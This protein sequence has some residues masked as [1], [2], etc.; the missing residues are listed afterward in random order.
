MGKIRA[1]TK[2]LMFCNVLLLILTA[3]TCA[4]SVVFNYRHIDDELKPFT[5]VYMGYLKTY[6]QNNNYYNPKFYTI[7]LEPE[8]ENPSW[9][10]VCEGKANGYKIKINKEWWDNNTD[11]DGRQ[12]LINHEMAH[13]LLGL[14][15]SKDEHNYMYYSFQRLDANEVRSQTT[16]DIYNT[17]NN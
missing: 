16:A 12:Q 8:M 14:E 7:E 11:K 2:I 10:G 4:K 9:I 5:N 6:C 15:H 3:K 17:C 1:L 13:C